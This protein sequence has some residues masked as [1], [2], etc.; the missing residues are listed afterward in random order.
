MVFVKRIVLDVLKPHLPSAIDFSQAIAR[1]GK[2]YRVR[3][4]VLE[5]D[6]N[7]QTLSL[8]VEAGSVDLAAIESAITSMGGS[9][10]SIDQVEVQN[11][12]DDG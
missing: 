7:T 5:M 12:A 11:D 3:L 6:E 9:L 8:E 10:H 1:V 2:D 4:T